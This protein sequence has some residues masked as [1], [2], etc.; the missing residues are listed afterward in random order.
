MKHPS[1]QKNDGCCH[2]GQEAHTKASSVHDES[3]HSSE[4]SGEYSRHHHANIEE[5]SGSRLLITLVLNLIIP[6]IQ[7]ISG[8]Y[9][10]SS[11]TRHYEKTP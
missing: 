11:L 8:I 7:I 1:L 5:T 10:I 9:A 2:T 3:S 4:C 6:V